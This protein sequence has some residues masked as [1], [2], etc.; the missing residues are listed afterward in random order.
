MLSPRFD[1]RE[2]GSESAPRQDR[3]DERILPGK[4][5][6]QSS[7]TASKRTG[8]VSDHSEHRESTR[9]GQSCDQTSVTI[10]REVERS[11]DRVTPLPPIP[12][13]LKFGWLR[14]LKNS[15]R[16][17][18]RKRS[19]SWKSLKIEK[20]SLLDARSGNLG[21]A[22]A[23]GIQAGQRNASRWRSGM[24]TAGSR[25]PSP[26]NTQGWVNAAGFREL[27]R[28]LCGPD[29]GLCPGLTGS[30]CSPF[31]RSR[32]SAW[33]GDR[34]AALDGGAPDNAPPSGQAV[35]NPSGIGHVALALAERKFV[36]AAEVEDIPNIELAQA[37]IT[38]DSETRNGRSA[39]ALRVTLPR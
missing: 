18:R 17:W 31:L 19:V 4:A 20:S 5:E 13:A 3:L 26:P 37:V 27:I 14:M 15:E 22:A 24:G 28:T 39:V 34:L 1:R 10:R 29:V 33:N 21:R 8:S 38:L 35:R 30:H 32:P 7:S 9:S 11:G 16:N 23:Q 12:G 2:S 25:W 36:T 6:S